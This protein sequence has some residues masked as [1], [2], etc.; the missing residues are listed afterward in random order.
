MHAGCY[1]PMRCMSAVLEFSRKPQ[2]DGDVGCVDES[3]KT[4]EVIAEIA[5]HF[6]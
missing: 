3:D 1:D 5:S 6:R 2:V 4:Y